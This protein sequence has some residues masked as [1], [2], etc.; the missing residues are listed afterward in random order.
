MNKT[1]GELVQFVLANRKG[2]AFI[3]FTEEQIA[4]EILQAAEENTMHYVI[5][6]D[7]NICGIV[8]ASKVEEMKMMFIKNIITTKPF[9]IKYFVQRFKELFPEYRLRAQRWHGPNK[10]RCDLVDYN[11]NKLCD[12]LMK[13]LN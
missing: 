1:L 8:I 2:K 9:A 6:N 4:S 3:G 11:T 13:G 10:S 5:D 7:K 12:K